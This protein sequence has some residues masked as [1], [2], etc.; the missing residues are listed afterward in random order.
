MRPDMPVKNKFLNKDQMVVVGGLIK[1]LL[2]QI[3]ID[4]EI[5]SLKLKNDKGQRRASSP[6]NSF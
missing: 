1:K 5:K 4:K 3:P 6:V 2:G